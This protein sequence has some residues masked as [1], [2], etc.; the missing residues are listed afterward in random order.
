M[1]ISVLILRFIW[2][3]NSNLTII[4][5]QAPIYLFIYLISPLFIAR[6]ATKCKSD[7]DKRAG[8]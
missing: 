3:F 5:C 8:N 7:E 2:E 1:S 6:L 4:D